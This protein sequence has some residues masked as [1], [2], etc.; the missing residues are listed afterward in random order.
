MLQLVLGRSGSGKTQWIYER[1]SALVDEE[2]DRPLLC[3]V[4]EQFSFETER[5]L[6]EALG[7]HRAARIQV[8]SFTRM[9]E[10]VFR[11]TGGFAG[12]KLDDSSRML[13]ISRALEMTSEQL[14]LYKRHAA[15][16]EYISS[17]LSILSELKQ[18]AVTPLTLEK[19]ARALPKGTLAMKAQELS[20]IYGAYEALLGRTY[21][22][23]LDDLTRLAEVLPQ[24][25]LWKEALLFIDAFKGFTAQEMQV[26]AAL[27]KIADTVTVTLCT[28]TLDDNAQG[29]GRF[30]PVIRTGT[31]LRQLAERQHVP[32][33]KPIVLSENHRSRSEAL[34]R[35][36]AECFRPDG[37]P[38]DTPADEVTL[39]ACADIYAECTFTARTIRR[40]LREEGARCRDFAI[41]TRD[42]GEYRGILDA[43][44]EMEGIPCFLDT[45]EDILTEPLVSMTLCALRCAEGLDTELLLRLM[46]TGLVGFSAHSIS[47]LE[48]YVLMWRIHG[49][50]WTRDWEGNPDGLDAPFTEDTVKKLD[51]LNRLRRR[52]VRPLEHLRY[53]LYPRTAAPS[54]DDGDGRLTGRE[55]AAAVY[56]YL[57]ETR[58]ARMVRLQVARLDRDGEHA[59]ADRYARLWDILIDRLDAFAAAM[60]NERLPANRLTEL[61]RLSLQATDLGSIPQSLDAVQIGAADRMRFSAPRTVFILGANEGIFPA[62]PTQ[63]GLLSD[64]ERQQLIELGLPLAEPS[65]QQTVEERFFAYMALSA[66]SERLYVSYRCSNA[67]GE[68]L[69]PSLLAETVSRLLP[70]CRRLTV[71]TEE[72][73]SLG[74]IESRTDAF[75]RMAE[76]WH[77]Q[78]A[79]ASSLKAFFSAQPEMHSRMEALQRAADDKPIA[80]RDP[81][82]ARQLF[83]REMRIS[84][85]QIEQYHKCRFAYFCQ[86]GLHLKAP[87]PAELDSLAFGTLAHYVMSALLPGYVETGLDGLTQA[88]VS[89]DT[90][91][92]VEQYVEERMGGLDNKPARFRHLLEQL[93]RTCA[94]LLWHVV[95]ELRQSR[96]VPAD[97]EL[98]IGIPPQDGEG[99]VPPVVLTLPDGARICVQGKVD[100]VDV[101]RDGVH[102]YV[103]VIDY[104][105]GDKAFRLSDV[106]EGLN[107]QMLLYLFALWQNGGAR[108]GEV[109]PAG[110]LYLPA[111]SPVIAISPLA[112]EAQAEDAHLRE[113]KMNGLLI[114]DPAVVSA[115][116]QEVAGVFIPAKLTAKGEFDSRYSSL[117]S[118]AQFGQL[119][120]RMEK[121]LTGMASALRSG[122]IEATPVKNKEKTACQYCPYRSICG[123]DND[124]ASRLITNRKN[125]E[126]FRELEQEEAAEKAVQTD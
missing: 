23:P 70:N 15:D 45:R 53:T 120:K 76:L 93:L 60:G 119:K 39:T 6:L 79:V 33:A 73:N 114:D 78:T 8:L 32:V 117:A 64:R 91:H 69:T 81:E 105:T 122:K 89:R 11:T 36:E 104:K 86:Y 95:Q 46:K 18:C 103:R 5:S 75:G 43:A 101:F 112:D 54:A 4:P 1:L 16:P 51:S 125:S 42:L 2:E 84:S 66:P 107:V 71:P 22:D 56:R 106:V 92:A 62:Y 118:L 88:Q 28:D 65:E 14:S 126:V 111:K 123:H 40:L 48:N 27:L 17:I 72:E 7:P 34:R 110:V 31:R 44:L 47:Q 109:T 63:N 41:V 10:T 59:L 61:F 82:A 113:M 96:F 50:G 74:G 30:S 29:L 97:Y 121:L 80:F 21:L 87:R 35:V 26:I 38:L 25:G 124:G 85:S 3:V 57:T 9:A 115:M 102:N 100:R 90:R 20:L 68:T 67:A 13:L 19:T 94:G 12:R 98:N 24:S 49:T 58:A 99:Y 77:S 37:N 55:F 52:L 83:G 116:E 108:Y